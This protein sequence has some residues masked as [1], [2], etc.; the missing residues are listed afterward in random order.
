MKRIW[1]VRWA[2]VVAFAAAFFASGCSKEKGTKG[3]KIKGTVVL[4]GKPLQFLPEEEVIVSLTELESRDKGVIGSAAQAKPPDAT[5]TID[6]PKGQGLPPGKYRIIVTSQIYG[7]D[8]GDRFEHLFSNNRPLLVA[9]IGA[10]EGQ[11]FVIDLGKMTV[12]K[13]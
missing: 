9:E 5:F 12:T 3:V 11:N 4:N 7:G 13:Q 8:T 10:E 6:G 2:I 1:A